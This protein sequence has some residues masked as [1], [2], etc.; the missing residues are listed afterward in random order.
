MSERATVRVFFLLLALSILSTVAVSAD[1]WWYSTAKALWLRGSIFVAL[2]VY[3]TL[4]LQYPKLRPNLRNPLN[5]AVL[6]FAAVNMLAALFGLDWARS[7]WGTY[8]RMNGV[9]HLLH[10]TL[11]YFYLLAMASAE[12]R[13]F[14]ILTTLLVWIAGLSSLYGLSEV[15]GLSLGPRDFFL[16]RE[17]RISG[18]FGNPIFFASFLILPM[19]LTIVR[20][21][22][23][24]TR[25]SK[26]IYE[27]LFALQFMALVFT[28]TRGALIGL[29][30]GVVVAG[31]LLLWKGQRMSNGPT[32]LLWLTIL[33]ASL[34]LPVILFPRSLQS[35]VFP[36]LAQLNDA[37]SSA[38]LIVWRMAW[39]AYTQHPLWGVG[40]ENYGAMFYKY[41]DRN[42]YRFID[43]YSFFDK[44]HNQVLE[45]LATTGSVGFLAYCAL[46]MLAIVGL[47]QGY[48]AGKLQWPA[49]VALVSGMV[50]YQVQNLFAFDTQAALVAFVFFIAFAGTQWIQSV[51]VRNSLTGRRVQ[52]PS[53]L[54]WTVLAGTAYCGHVVYGSAAEVSG[55]IGAAVST[56]DT[57][58]AIALLAGAARS[59]FAWDRAELASAYVL[60][61][62][63]GDETLTTE[64]LN[65]A[66][67]DATRFLEQTTKQSPNDPALWLKLATLYSWKSTLNRSPADF[68]AGLAIHRAMAL[69]PNWIEPLSYLAQYEASCKHYGEAEQLAVRMVEL[70]PESAEARWNLAWVYKLDNREELAIKTAWIALDMGYRFQ[71]DKEVRW[72]SDYYSEKQD[73]HQLVEVYKKAIQTRPYD[74]SSYRRLATTYVKLGAK[75]KA[76]AMAIQASQLD[77]SDR[78]WPAFVHSLE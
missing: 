67:D 45:L 65:M 17:H 36:H 1:N 18:I 58:R 64:Q 47:W 60:R 51:P 14:K 55:Q 73:Y 35:L 9:F 41:F 30:V 49:F 77:P 21:L 25:L 38:R 43:Y 72:L 50:A 74:M 78:E 48:K 62:T 56:K 42:L 40:P 34:A 59:P 39:R 3:L 7:F 4:L 69:A 23:S 20:W 19:A 31:V 68:H 33:L 37:S 54:F 28:G 16:A 44:P 27:V 29:A 12:P 70:L 76:I 46:V 75:Q 15:L 11:L 32:R 52:V 24:G 10:L 22:Q 13:C 2:P 5:L 57:P 63:D 26:N 61:L 53:F 6:T 71:S 66:L 8:L